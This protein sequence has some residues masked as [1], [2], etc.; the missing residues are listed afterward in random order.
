MVTVHSVRTTFPDHS[1]EE[2]A[3]PSPKHAES[4][5]F[6]EMCSA[7]FPSAAADSVESGLDLNEHLVKYHAAKF[8]FDVC[9]DQ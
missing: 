8:I 2:Q 7:G 9:S 4:L 3:F 5:L 6:L 1:V